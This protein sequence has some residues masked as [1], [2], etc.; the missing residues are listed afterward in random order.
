MTKTL[1]RN[2]W[3]G[4][5]LRKHAGRWKRTQGWAYRIRVRRDLC[6]H[7]ELRLQLEE[8]NPR[9]HFIG[10]ITKGNTDA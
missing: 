6:S 10:T 3:P 2:R 1:Y 8:T 7:R 5:H 9:R 4:Y